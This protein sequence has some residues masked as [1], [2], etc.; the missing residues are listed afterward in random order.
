MIIEWSIYGHQKIW[1]IQLLKAKHN[2]SLGFL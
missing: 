2:F 1:E